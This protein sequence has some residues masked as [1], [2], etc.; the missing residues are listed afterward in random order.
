MRSGGDHSSRRRAPEHAVWQGQ[1]FSRSGK[2][3]RY[4]DFV[5]STGYGSGSGLGGWNCRHSFSPYFEGDPKTYSKQ[6]LEDFEAKDYEYNGQKMTEYEATRQQRYVE[7]QIRRWK[8]ENAAMAARWPGHIRECIQD[9]AVAGNTK[10]FPASDRIKATG[11]P[12]A[13]SDEGACKCLRFWYNKNRRWEN[14]DKQ[15]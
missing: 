12:G 1:I 9:T 4:P 5:S 10:R 13:D 11:G 8:R 6:M 2:S 7:R 14:D 3:D 15:Y